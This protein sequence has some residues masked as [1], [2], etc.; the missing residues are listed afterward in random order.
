MNVSDVGTA[1]SNTKLIAVVAIVLVVAAMFVYY[2]GLQSQNATDY[3]LTIKSLQSNVSELQFSNQALQ[4]E[5]EALSKQGNATVGANPVQLYTTA[6]ASVVTVQGDEVTTVNTF[7][8]PITSVSTV[9]GSGFVVAYGNSSYIVTN[10]HV[11]DGV[12]NLTATFSDGNAFAARVVGSDKYSDIAVLSI[13]TPGKML[14]SL[15]LAGAGKGASVGEAVYAI[16]NPFGL[17]GSM[18]FGIVSQTDRT[19]T[20][21]TS[22]QVTISG[23]I[24]FSAPINPGNS[25]GPLIDSSGLVVGMTTAS[26]TN[27]QG[28]YFAIPSSTIVR[29]LPS[30]IETGTYNKHPYLGINGTDMGYQ[31]AQA[32]GVNVTY[33]VLVEQVASNSPASKGGMTGGSR[34]VQIEGNT[35]LVGGDVI[36][37]V[38]GFRVV[39]QDALA[40]YLEENVIAGQTVALGIVRGGAFT[41]VNVTL[42]YLPSS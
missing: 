28:L 33:G 41:S 32:N 9:L 23:I 22:S 14:T 5:V 19:I 12:S 27:S 1:R 10:F 29:E 40:S 31:L 2:E 18:T 25:G 7:F 38:N 21:S 15:T 13:S 36:V 11:V 3:S 35:Y 30:L 26:A 17:S 4:A 42:G 24:Q 6:Q 37:S 34:S 39:N 20:E 16:G 8:G